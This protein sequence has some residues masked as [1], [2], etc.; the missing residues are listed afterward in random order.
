[1]ATSR[2]GWSAVETVPAAVDLNDLDNDG[3]VLQLHMTVNHLSRWLSSVHDQSRLRRTPQRGLLSIHELVIRLRDEEVR[4]FQRIYAI[5]VRNQPNLDAL[6]EASRTAADAR[7]DREATVIEQ[8]A[9]FRRLRQSTCSLLRSLPDSAWN[10]SGISR[11]EHNWTIRGLAEHLVHHDRTVLV[12]MD[13]ALNLNGA[14]EG[15]A[16]AAKISAEDL[17]GIVRSRRS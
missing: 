1:M 10:R 7:H 16:S 14:R 8:V 4:I 3:V 17:L 6:V 5:S 15:I 13:H 12:E 9:E 2:I 11:R